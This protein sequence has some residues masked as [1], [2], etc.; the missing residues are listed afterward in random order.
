MSEKY[1]ALLGKVMQRRP[2]IITFG[3]IVF[4]S[5]PMMFK[6]IPSE[7]AP[8]EDNGVVMLMGTA[9]ANANLDFIDNTMSQVNKIL[10]SQPEV[11]FAQVFSGVP[12]SN[13]AFGIASLKPWSEREASQAEVA[14]WSKKF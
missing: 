13:Q 1:N 4:L 6:F 5:L 14:G 10:S 8:S 9:P 2:V 11:K 7:L 12:S 3:I